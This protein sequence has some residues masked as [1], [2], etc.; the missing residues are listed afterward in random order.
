MFV[1]IFEVKPRPEKW[2]DYL[3]NAKLLLPDLER[4]DGFIDNERFAS[5]RRSGWV[6]SLSTWRDEK[7]VIRWRTFAAHH[8]I[9]L[10]G[11]EEIFEDY[12]LRVG[13]V[14][15]DSH[16]PAGHGLVQQRFDTTET[17]AAAM[18]TLIE[19]LD[20]PA[21]IEQIAGERTVRTHESAL[22]NND[23]EGFHLSSDAGNA[24]AAGLVDWDAFESITAP[25]K[26]ILLESWRDSGHSPPAGPGRVRQVRVIRDYAMRDRRE[27]PQYY[28][29]PP[30]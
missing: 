16:V 19:G 1:V 13:E 5:R 29:A 23:P 22:R 3:A 4:I 2:D 25:G 21:N 26:L 28:P 8:E 11:R 18:V 20:R 7:S 30:R 9:Q 15:A 10:K 17:G 24:L 27:A 14:T 6:L 12:H